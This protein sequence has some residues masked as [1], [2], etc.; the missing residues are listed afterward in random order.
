MGGLAATM[1]LWS[2]VF[3]FFMLA[4]IGLPGLSGF[5]GE[6]LVF[7]GSF[8]YAPSIAVASII[9]MVLAATYLMWMFQR[10]AFGAVSDFLTGLGDHLTD[11]SRVEFVTLAPLAA[12]IVLFGLF[13]SLIL[14]FL[15]GPI[16]H[17]LLAA[18]SAVGG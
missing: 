12:L 3:G 10:V 1:P 13:P 4:S 11:M 8:T 7:V 16:Q 6:F 2:T 9:V 18:G 17:F 14:D 15:N 5:V